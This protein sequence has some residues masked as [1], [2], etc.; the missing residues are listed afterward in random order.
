[1]LI[2]QVYGFL[3]EVDVELSV[4][5]KLFGKPLTSLFW[6]CLGEVEP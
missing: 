2:I 3:L 6:R 5:E 1:M 4:H